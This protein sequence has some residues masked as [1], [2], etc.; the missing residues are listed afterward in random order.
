MGTTLYRVFVFKIVGNIFLLKM[1]KGVGMGNSDG[2]NSKINKETKMSKR[3][4][5]GMLV[6]SFIFGLMLVLNASPVK[7][8]GIIKGHVYDTQGN[9]LAGVIL[10]AKDIATGQDSKTIS[11][12]NGYFIFKNMAFGTYKV[13][14]ELPGTKSL[15][16]RVELSA[17]KKQ[18]TLMFQLEALPM[19][20]EKEEVLMDKAV[21]SAI[22]GGVRREG[23]KRGNF[24][25]SPSEAP[26]P[27]SH[28]SQFNTEE[29]DRIYENIFLDA[30][31]NPLSTFSIDVDTA[32]YANIRRFINSNQ[33]PYK[34]AVRIEE[35]INYFSYD[36]PLPTKKHP[37]SIYTEISGCPWNPDHRLIHIGLQGKMLEDKHLPPSNLV[38]LLDV[39]GSM[40][41]ANKL[42]LLKKA[43]KLL[44]NELSEKDRVSIVVYAGAAGLVL[45]STP[46]NQKDKIF[47]ALD[48]LSAG[49]STAGGA[50]IQLA[51]KVAWENFIPDG[52]NRIILATDG[53]FNI[54]ISST[55]ELVRKI[56][57]KRKKGIFLTILGFGM[58]NYKD[59]RMEQI[60]DKGNGNYHYI[61]NLLEAKKVFV[62]DMRGTLFTIAK[63]V[64]IQVE[65]NPAKVKA[66]R[67]IGYENRL[68]KKEDFDDDTKDAGEL[69]AGHTVTALYEVI[70]Y[71]SKEEVPVVGDLKYQMVRIDPKAYKSKEIL[72]VKL[73]YKKPDGNK[74]QLLDIPLADK[75]IAIAKASEN[76]K[77]SAAIAEFGMLL[78]DSEFKGQSSYE[79]VLELAKQG[80][81]PDSFGYRTEFIKLVE[82]CQLLDTVSSK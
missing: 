78:R 75:N 16:L 5:F 40:E 55:S 24:Q 60:A 51:Y 47:A 57:E 36:Y 15:V 68:L 25:M 76:F 48:R 37:F 46:A 17:N 45:P 35:M 32:S 18:A 1:Y 64:K 71:G 23:K 14:A 31:K 3:N 42:P 2:V 69:G 67:L 29:Y 70:P 9:A 12:Q 8:F 80:K 73:R 72:T 63:D 30:L 50:G 53:D 49:G 61:D 4:W 62:N 21:A 81:G 34:D 58:G 10:T 19:L 65:F 77:F 74:S 41:P 7:N 6:L 56:E 26:Y 39:S 27:A 33:Y 82:M 44:I 59:G 28:S 79:D 13:K 54:G 20:T 66:Y 22:V 11:G 38:F 52:N 43:F